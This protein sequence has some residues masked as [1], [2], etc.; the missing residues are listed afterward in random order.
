[1]N[2][3][4]ADGFLASQLLLKQTDKRTESTLVLRPT[5]RTDPAGQNR[6]ASAGRADWAK[7]QTVKNQRKEESVGSATKSES[8]NTSRS[9][10]TNIAK[11]NAINTYILLVQLE[12]TIQLKT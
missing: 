9:Q 6:I 3:A 2:A 1:M 7:R 12:S 11:Q 5:I 10:T 4:P 8:R